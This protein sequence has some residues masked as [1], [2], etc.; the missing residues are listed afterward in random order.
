MNFD[1][2]ELEEIKQSDENQL[3][4]V[5]TSA[6]DFCTRL[7]HVYISRLMNRESRKDPVKCLKFQASIFCIIDHYQ[8]NLKRSPAS[9][10]RTLERNYDLSER[11]DLIALSS[12]INHFHHHWFVT[13]LELIDAGA[14]TGE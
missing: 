10:M 2:P 8:T 7:D 13:A 5:F 12:H 6:E 3:N 1:N 4:I 14:F 11:D 9:R